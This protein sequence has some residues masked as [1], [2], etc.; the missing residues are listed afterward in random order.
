MRSV[1]R[2]ENALF[3]LFTFESLGLEEIEFYFALA[4]C[5]ECEQRACAAPSQ[6]RMANCTD[7][8]AC[9]TCPTMAPIASF[10]EPL[11]TFRT[12]RIQWME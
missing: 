5:G 8:L 4:F 12:N 9:C 7:R 2:E 3:D 10:G 1:E 6:S 11:F